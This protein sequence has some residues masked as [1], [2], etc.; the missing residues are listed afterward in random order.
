MKL[1]VFFKFNIKNY[2]LEVKLLKI[3]ITIVNLVGKNKPNLAKHLIELK[4]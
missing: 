4:Y 3:I 2:I 1:A